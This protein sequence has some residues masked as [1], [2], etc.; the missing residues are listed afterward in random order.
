MTCKLQCTW[1]SYEKTEKEKQYKEKTCALFLRKQFYLQYIITLA[2][3][4]CFLFSCADL[5]LHWN[6]LLTGFSFSIKIL[7]AIIT[8]LFWILLCYLLNM[9]SFCIGSISRC[10]FVVTFSA[11]LASP[12]SNIPCIPIAMPVLR[13]CSVFRSSWF[14]SMPPFQWLQ[15]SR[16]NPKLIRG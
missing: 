14:Y 7:L 4:F 6:C 11:A 8:F 15:R 13:R 16:K 12:C 2:Q 5:L 10:Y 1:T 9:S 3:V